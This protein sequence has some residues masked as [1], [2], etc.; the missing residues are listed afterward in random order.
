MITRD[1]VRHVAKLARLALTPEEE[2]LFTEQLGH[3]LGHVE[4]LQAVDTQGVEPSSTALPLTNVLR[5][6]VERPSLT[7]EEAL[8]NAPQPEAGMFRVPQILS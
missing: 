4:Q 8:A 1:T 7:R 5:E 6:D 2:A 3:I